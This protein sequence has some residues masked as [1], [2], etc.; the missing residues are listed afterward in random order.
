MLVYDLPGG[1]GSKFQAG[2]PE[3]SLEPLDWG[4]ATGTYATAE[5]R[6]LVAVKRLGILGVTFM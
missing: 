1:G 2:H 4:T 3:I 6:L 5:T